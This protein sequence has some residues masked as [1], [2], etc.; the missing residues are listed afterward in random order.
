[1]GGPITP[2]AIELFVPIDR[3]GGSVERKELTARHVLR[4]NFCVELRPQS[5]YSRESADHNKANLR[6]PGYLV[7][8]AM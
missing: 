8:T 1:M 6:C 3:A 2:T 4:W 5:P 7:A